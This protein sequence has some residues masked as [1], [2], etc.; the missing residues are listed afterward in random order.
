MRAPPAGCCPRCDSCEMIQ[1]GHHELA[2][3][4][5]TR[6]PERV[7]VPMGRPRTVG[8]GTH[9]PPLVCQSGLSQPPLS[10]ADSKDHTAEQTLD[11]QPSTETSFMILFSW[12]LEEHG[13]RALSVGYQARA[14]ARDCIAPLVAASR[15]WSRSISGSS[16]QARPGAWSPARTEPY[17]TEESEVICYH[18]SIARL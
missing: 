11:Q 4:V 10:Y 6:S 16:P 1:Q 14:Q 7:C 17:W 12:G 8:D 2:A 18:L 13:R 15:A 3:R 9:R 5:V